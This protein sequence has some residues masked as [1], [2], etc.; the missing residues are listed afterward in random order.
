[1]SGDIDKLNSQISPLKAANEALQAENKQITSS[2]N[3]LKW[4]AGLLVVAGFFFA[5][6]GM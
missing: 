5:G 1:L 4:L 3:T 2:G 6:G